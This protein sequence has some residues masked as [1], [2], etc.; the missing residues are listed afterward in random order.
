M[1]WVPGNCLVNV[2][3]L[4]QAAAPKV[5]NT[6]TPT[7]GSEAGSL[8]KGTRSPGRIGLAHQPLLLCSVSSSA[9][10]LQAS[11]AYDSE[12]AALSV[13][14]RRIIRIRSSYRFVVGRDLAVLGQNFVGRVLCHYALTRARGRFFTCGAEAY[15][16]TTAKTVQTSK[17]AACAVPDRTA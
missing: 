1:G 10:E 16:S 15:Q 12:D 14:H 3:S 2:R 11:C 7:P 13:S 17:H 4:L 6:F 8:L 5:Q 9:C